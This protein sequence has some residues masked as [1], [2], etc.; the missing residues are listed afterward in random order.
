MWL[1][2]I[3]LKKMVHIKNFSVRKKSAKKLNKSG[4]RM[5]SYN[6]FS[7]KVGHEVTECEKNPNQDF[8]GT[9]ISVP[10]FA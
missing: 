5:T 9:S 4:L 7:D 8:L 1:R 3:G 2:G 10:V 6:S